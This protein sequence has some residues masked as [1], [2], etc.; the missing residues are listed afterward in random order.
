MS[1]Q[2]FN[3]FNSFVE[4]VCEKAHNLGS[5]VLKV[6]LT[7]TLPNVST[8]V[9]YADISST[10]LA[11]GAGYT[12]G[13][14]APTITSSAQ[15]GGIYKLVLADAVWTASASMGP[16][17]YAVLYNNTDTVTPKGLIGFWDN[18]SSVT[19]ANTETFTVDYDPTTGV[20]QLQ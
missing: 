18:G 19:L 6:M 9:K 1:I 14:I 16:F 11:N 12:T 4:A 5:D 13:G 7:N 8:S 3:K 10:E 20:L 17:R 2:P 15:T